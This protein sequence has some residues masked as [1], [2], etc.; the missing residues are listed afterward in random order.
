MQY[1]ALR[2]HVSFAYPMFQKR[3]QEENV[4]PQGSIGTGSLTWCTTEMIHNQHFPQALILRYLLGSLLF[5][6]CIRKLPRMNQ[7]LKVEGWG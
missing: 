3:L 7:N 6:F 4:Y 2:S 5:C 1:E